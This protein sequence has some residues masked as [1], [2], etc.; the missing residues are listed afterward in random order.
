MSN[1]QTPFTRLFVRRKKKLIINISKGIQEPKLA[2][3]GAIK[4]MLTYSIGRVTTV[5]EWPI[6]QKPIPMPETLSPPELKVNRFKFLNL[7]IIGRKT[8]AFSQHSSDMYFDREDFISGAHMT[9][10]VDVYKI[11]K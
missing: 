9:V 3:I 1:E 4:L 11:K 2:T 5:S 7:K 8:F 6:C 10:L